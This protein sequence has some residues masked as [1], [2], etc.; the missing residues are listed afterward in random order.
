MF[1]FQIVFLLIAEEENRVSCFSPQLDDNANGA[2]AR[3]ELHHLSNSACEEYT[4]NL[5]QLDPVSQIQDSCTRTPEEA[6]DENYK[7]T[8]TVTD[9][10][11]DSPRNQD[12]GNCELV[13]VGDVLCVEC[14]QLVFRPVVLNCGHGNDCNLISYLYNFGFHVSN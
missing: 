8:G 5:E 10:K 1:P 7:V 9:N 13:T 4:A 6:P 14:K 3:Q 11:T 2:V 12:S